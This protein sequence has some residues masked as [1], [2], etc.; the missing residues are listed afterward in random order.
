ME[1]QRILVSELFI[2]LVDLFQVTYKWLSR[3]LSVPVNKAK[4]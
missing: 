3:T 1:N 2:F 4:Q